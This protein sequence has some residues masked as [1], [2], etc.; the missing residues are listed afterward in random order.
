M[1]K[2]TRRNNKHGH[3]NILL[4]NYLHELAD[5]MGR[6]KILEGQDCILTIHILQEPNR[7]AKFAKIIYD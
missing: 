1:N 3:D 5:M 4:D 7:N 2:K 6:L